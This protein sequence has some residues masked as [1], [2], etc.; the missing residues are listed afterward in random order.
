MKKKIWLIASLVIGLVALFFVL[1]FV[2]FKEVLDSFMAAD[3]KNIV[4]YLLISVS[5]MIVLAWRWKTI[6]KSQNLK[7]PFLNIFN[8]M[9]VGYG[10]SYLT[11]SAKIGGEP[12]RAL[13]LSNHDIKFPKALSSVIIDKTI[14]ISSSALFFFMGAILVVFKFALPGK[15]SVMLILSSTIL[16]GGMIFIYHRLAS[17]KGFIL[18]LFHLLK[19]DRIKSLKI[20]EYKIKNFE[21]LIIKFFQHDKKYF[22]MAMLM[23]LIA[24]ILMFLEFKLVLLMLGQDVSF[25][26][27]FLIVSFLGAAFLFPIPLGLGAVEASQVFVF[28]MI[29]MKSVAGIALALLTRARDIVWSIIGLI[30]LSYYGLSAKKTIKKAYDNHDMEK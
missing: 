29:G 27:I 14:E 15:T 9:I 16:L 18:G 6:L 17:G 21:G 7:V 26:A 30:L 12:I 24:W 20:T 8:Y 3:T 2:S 10:I 13:L 22:L 25:T 19:I 1:R 28:P 5:I 4:G 23:S 11:P